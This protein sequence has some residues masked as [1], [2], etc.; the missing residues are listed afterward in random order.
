MELIERVHRDRG[1]EDARIGRASRFD[2]LTKRA[3]DIAVASLLLL[4]A[5]P[6]ILCVALCIKLESPGPVLFRCRRVGHRGRELAMLKF[7]KMHDGARGPA[8]TLAED[9]RFT[10]IGKFLAA[11]KLDELPQLWNVLRGDM[12]LVGPRPETREFV[13]LEPEA[14]AAILRGRP[15]ITGL[16]Q[17]AYAREGEILDPTDRVSD[18]LAR[19]MPQKLGLDQLY[20]E[21]RTVMG[22]IRILMWTL[23]TVV[24][25]IEVA[26]DRSSARLNRRAPR[27][28]R[29]VARIEPPHAFASHAVTQI[30]ADVA[31]SA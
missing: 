26:V 7:R 6:L 14:Y 4:L 30:P 24:L 11:T 23:I 18:Y 21:Q 9:E 8:L 25:R 22:D 31:E 10:R 16:S 27:G 13:E 3:L 1:V 17:L 28:V 29:E 12:S 20:V 15:G 19:V 5:L 2:E